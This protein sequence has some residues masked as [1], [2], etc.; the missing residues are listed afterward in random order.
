FGAKPALVQSNTFGSISSQLGTSSFGNAPTSQAG[1]SGVFGGITTAQPISNGFGG[2]AQPSQATSN[3]F[4]SSGGGLG[5]GSNSGQRN[6]G[7][8]GPSA[9]NFAFGGASNT[10]AFG[11]GTSTAPGLASQFLFGQSNQT[12]STAGFRFG[13]GG[14]PVSGSVPPT[15]FTFG[16]NTSVQEGGGPPMSHFQFAAGGVAQHSSTGVSG[17]MSLGRVTG[18]AS[19]VS[20]SSHGRRIAR[21]RRRG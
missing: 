1:S 13:S 11:A 7:G 5:F 21:P 3:A 6:P 16:S 17:G 14:A 15:P 8:F 18:S 20:A 12:P 9:G 19:N 4:G 10:S 2:N